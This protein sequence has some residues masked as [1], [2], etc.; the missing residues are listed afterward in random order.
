MKGSSM[1]EM[2]ARIRS[3]LRIKRHTDE[4]ESAEAGLATVARIVERRDAFV[5]DHCKEVA[6]L[7]EKLGES[8]G[9]SPDMVQR[10]RVGA[11][12]HDIGK[13][14]I[15][16]A[17]L[18]KPGPLNDAERAKMMTHVAVGSELVE[19]MHTLAAILP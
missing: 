13:I 10:L 18:Q 19:P 5:S 7:C 8:L 4:V 9:L 1:Q 3:L 2:L 12:F 16:D 11:A 17:I 6:L 14:V 15:E